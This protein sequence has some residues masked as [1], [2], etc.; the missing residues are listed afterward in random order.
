MRGSYVALEGIEG[1]GKSTIAGLVASHLR[2][3][4]SE[5]VLVREPGGT[6]L[7]EEIRRLLLHSGEMSPWAEAALF[8]ASRAQL[9][10]EVVGPA[11][12]RGALVI[13]DR[14]YYSS[15]AYQGHAR[16]LGVVEVRALN[17]AVLGGTLPDLVVVLEI[18]P[19]VGLDRQVDPDRIGGA[20]LGFQRRVAE[21][22]RLLAGQ[23][24]S[25][26]RLVP[27]S[28]APDQVASRVVDLIGSL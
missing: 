10:A 5:V 26:V 1:A 2:S 23:E 28:D 22:Y 4:G 12:E 15:L 24:P 20:G 6:E 16:G 25:L 8:A 11:L 17:E 18:D 13:S 21:G 9:V 19:G 3:A 7:G 14:T 27:A